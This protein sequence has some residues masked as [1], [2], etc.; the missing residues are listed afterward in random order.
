MATALQ[1]EKAIA[2]HIN[3]LIAPENAYTGNDATGAIIDAVRNF[4]ATEH[5]SY[6]TG[7]IRKK[8]AMIAGGLGFITLLLG[9]ATGSNLVIGFAAMFFLVLTVWAL[10]YVANPGF[11]MIANFFLG[12]STRILSK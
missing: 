2:D 3:A 12:R 5:H 6:I 4:E 8:M 11:A 9:I 7:K 1:K 10:I